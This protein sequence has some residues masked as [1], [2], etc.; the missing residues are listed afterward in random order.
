MSEPQPSQPQ[1]TGFPVGTKTVDLAISGMS[2]TSCVQRLEKALSQVQGVE[3]V[4]VNLATER[5]RVNYGNRAITPEILVQQ[6]EKAGY[7]AVLIKDPL[8]IPDQTQTKAAPSDLDHQGRLVMVGALLALPLVVPMVLEPFGLHFML[9]G[10]TP[11]IF[12]LPIQF[13]L[14]ARFYKAAWSAL[15]AGA[16]NMDLLVVLGTSAAFGLSVYNLF[17]GSRALYFESAAVIIVMVLLG[18]YLESRAKHQTSQAL[19]SLQ[20]IIPDRARLRRP[21]GDQEV[22]LS[23]V[24]LGDLVVVGPGEKIPVDGRVLQGSS[25]VDE[26][27]VSGE[28]LPRTKSPG[29]IVT[30]GTLN[31]DGQLIVTTVALGA[32]STLARMIRLVENA[33]M[34]KAPIQRLVDRVS[35]V[36]VPTVLG[37]AFLTFFL[38]GMVTGQ[39]EAALL[40]GVAVLVIACP[41]ALGL[42]TPTS[43]MVGTGMAAQQGILIKDAEAL[44]TAHK[45]TTIVFD[46]TGTLTQGRPE[47]VGIFPQSGDREE[48]LRITAAVQDGSEHPLAKAVV[49]SAKKQNL[50]YVPARNIQAVPGKGVVG[51][52][53]KQTIVVGSLALMNSL[54]IEVLP[55]KVSKDFVPDDGLTV[56]YVANQDQTKFLG[57]I[58][59]RDALKPEAAKAIRILS[60]LGIKTVLITGDNPASARRVAQE[61]GIAD[62]RAEVLPEAKAN[63]VTSLK[64]TGKEGKGGEIVA[65]VGDG[66][67]DAP[68]LATADIGIAMATGTDV[69]MHTA[70]ITLMHGNPLL[71]PDALEISRKTYQK[72]KQNLF[73]AFIYNILGIPLAAF[74]LLSPMVAGAAMALS[75]ASVVGSALLL[76]RWKP[77]SHR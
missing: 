40:H 46:K 67:N 71:I 51:Q 10:W 24:R 68:A 45:V 36:F 65:M 27:L 74:G 28:G 37:I 69:A 77:S 32:E 43:I 57:M 33:Q 22:S 62:W 18:K 4:Q 15:R 72:I 29:D 2:C 5:A 30:G 26:S 35:N 52:V 21:D 50:S 42:A 38:W 44:E 53:D 25:L 64:G 39:W 11:L 16:G 7:K 56:S 12:A 49:D 17:M 54:K 3:T 6:V 13:W 14:G 75:S 55:P 19:R 60:G 58:T 34:A 23:Q 8:S 73:W 31:G 59:F 66:I 61:V 76:K 63:M 48:L 9:P 47:I 1:P 70:G 41:C 20:A